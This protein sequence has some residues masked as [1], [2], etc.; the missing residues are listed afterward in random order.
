M[1][2]VPY[3]LSLSKAY[4]EQLY[5]DLLS[6]HAEGIIVRHPFSNYARGYSHDIYKYKVYAFIHPTQ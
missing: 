5:D 4:T 2:L 3:V 6:V 1:R